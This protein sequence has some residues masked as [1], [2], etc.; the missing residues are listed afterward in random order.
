[1]Y[2]VSTG[3]EQDGVAAPATV[4]TVTVTFPSTTAAGAYRISIKK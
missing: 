4:N 3:I 1:V 2:E